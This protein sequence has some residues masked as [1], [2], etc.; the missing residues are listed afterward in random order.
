MTRWSVPRRSRSF[1]CRWEGYAS[2][3][4]TSALADFREEKVLGGGVLKPEPFFVV[5][6]VEEGEAILGVPGVPFCFFRLSKNR[7]KGLRVPKPNTALLLV[8]M[9][10]SNSS[11]EC[12]IYSSSPSW[13]MTLNALSSPEDMVAS[14]LGLG[15]PVLSLSVWSS[16][17]TTS[18]HTQR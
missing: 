5:G 14:V 17:M 6:G 12:S 16:S 3:Y 11:R 8:S 4:A 13:L 15:L 18:Y 7:K 2:S 1:L 10:S 9:C